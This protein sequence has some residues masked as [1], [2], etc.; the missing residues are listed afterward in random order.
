MKA[1]HAHVFCWIIL[2]VLLVTFI[3]LNILK[4][5]VFLLFMY[6]VTDLLMHGMGKR[7]P[8]LSKR[9]ILFLSYFLVLGS[10]L[11][12]VFWVLPQFISE[13][14]VYMERQLASL[15]PRLAEIG[16]NL[17]TSFKFVE[18]KEKALVWIQGHLS[19]TFE[20][21][22]RTGTTVFLF[23]FALILNLLIACRVASGNGAKTNESSSKDSLLEYF[24]TFITE[25]ISCFYSY[26]KQVMAAQVIISAINTV[27]TVI[28][29]IILGIP[30]KITLGVFCFLFGLIPVVG[31]LISNT[32]ICLAAFLWS[33]TWQAVV[34]LIFLVGIHKLEYFLNGKIVGHIVK[35]PV[36][37]ALLALL[38]GESM[39][40][41]SGMIVAIPALLF[42]RNEMKNTHVVHNGDI[43]SNAS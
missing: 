7:I 35:L 16:V 8:F 22:K 37:L 6:L 18:L 5:L 43:V 17:E 24:S 38:I 2:L 32:V 25:K 41:I 12:I 39:F 23:I 15:K 10:A 3:H 31:N 29:L 42:I 30:H 19:G 28:L 36:Y 13:F 34:I 9:V 27:L 14:P 4:F 11:F 40:H 20:F 21:I 33:G 26:F 1:K